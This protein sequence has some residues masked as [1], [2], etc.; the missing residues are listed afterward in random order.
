MGKLNVVSAVANLQKEMEYYR[1]IAQECREVI[2]QL[3]GEVLP[4][5]YK[6]IHPA[7]VAWLFNQTKNEN[8]DVRKL[9]IAKNCKE[10]NF[11]VIDG[12][13]YKQSVYMPIEHKDFMK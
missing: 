9:G 2:R 6:Y 1:E 13:T 11:L 12:Q 8:F 7:D 5:G 3:A 10:E 4:G